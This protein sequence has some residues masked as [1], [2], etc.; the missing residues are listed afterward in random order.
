MLPAECLPVWSVSTRATV[1]CPILAGVTASALPGVAVQVGAADAGGDD[2]Q[3]GIARP[4]LGLGTVS[5]R[6]YR[7]EHRFA[8]QPQERWIREALLRASGRG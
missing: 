6:L 7:L 5:C 4:R 8:G 3:E 1:S 2:L